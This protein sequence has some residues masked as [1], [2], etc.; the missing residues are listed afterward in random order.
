VEKK[1]EEPAAE[2]KA[3]QAKAPAP[4][5][6]AVKEAE[7]KEPEK[8]AEEAAKAPIVVKPPQA[9]NSGGAQMPSFGSFSAAMPG[10]G[11]AV[12]VTVPPTD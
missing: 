11:N 1:A 3:T 9:T 10:Q 8:K 12:V 5:Q 7:I 4:V 6:E 2:P